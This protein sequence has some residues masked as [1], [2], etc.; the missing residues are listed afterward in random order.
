MRSA[1][2]ACCTRSRSRNAIPDTRSRRACRR[3]MRR[4]GYA[5]KYIVVV[6]DDVDV[7]ISTSCCGRCSRAPTQGIDPVH[8][9][10]W[11]SSADPALRRSGALSAT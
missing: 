2:R 1:A 5:S 6:D 9:G 7:T 10:S 8:H 4:L 11:D 3:T